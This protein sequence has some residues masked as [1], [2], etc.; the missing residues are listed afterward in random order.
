MK[1]FMKALQIMG[2]VSTWSVTALEDEKVTL[3]EATE[4]VQGI[5]DILGVALEV[6]L[7]ESE[8]G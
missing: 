2:L 8:S 5:C 4:L 3:T 1:Y 6:D 7:G